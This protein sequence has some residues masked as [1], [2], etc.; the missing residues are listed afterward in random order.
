M[1]LKAIIVE[2]EKS[3]RETLQRYVLKYCPDISIVGLAEN[4]N[5]GLELIQSQQP[6]IVF[7]DVEMPYGNGFDLLEKAGDASFA[8]IFV[9]AFGE[10]AMKA[11]NFSASYYI[12]KPIDIDELIKAVDKVKKEKETNSHTISS[13]ILIENLKLLRQNY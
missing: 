12:L 11:L 10:Y 6:D 9:T 8:T 3:N 13:K 4:I 7:L 2:D 5:T 1:K